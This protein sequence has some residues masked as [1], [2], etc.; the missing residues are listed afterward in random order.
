[1]HGQLAADYAG[2]AKSVTGK[3]FFQQL[4]IKRL[5]GFTGGPFLF[6]KSCLEQNYYYHR[7]KHNLL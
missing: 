6:L 3:S 2:D 7:K 4:E 1:M 5:T